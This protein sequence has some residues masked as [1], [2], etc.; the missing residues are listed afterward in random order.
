MTIEQRSYFYE[1]DKSFDKQTR[2]EYLC[3]MM[4][5]IGTAYKLKPTYLA[6]NIAP[7]VNVNLWEGKFRQGNTETHLSLGCT[8]A[9]VKQGLDKDGKQLY[10]KEYDMLMFSCKEH[11]INKK[12]AHKVDSILYTKETDN[13]RLD[14]YQL[15]FKKMAVV[16]VDYFVNTVLHIVSRV[17]DNPNCIAL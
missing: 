6:D 16:D 2:I 1:D 5:D 17:I 7:G 12:V 14:V 13:N 4:N 8:V 15:H 3:E 9:W 11:A 10:T